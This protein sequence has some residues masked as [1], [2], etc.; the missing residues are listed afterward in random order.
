MPG[1][2]AHNGDE[3]NIVGESRDMQDDI[4]ENIGRTLDTLLRPRT[5]LP[6]SG[7]LRV[8][9]LGGMSDAA[10]DASLEVVYTNQG[11]EVGDISAYDQIPP[12]DILSVGLPSA[13]QDAAFAFALRFLR[14]RR[15]VAFLLSAAVQDSIRADFRRAVET[16][17]GRLG[18]RHSHTA[19]AF[20][21]GALWP[22][23]FTWPD[24]L[25]A[26][27]VLAQVAKDA[28]VYTAN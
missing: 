16:R 5:P 24:D 1:A 6:A 28:M 12:F 21:V 11:E 3:R 10:R 8:A 9:V 26:T 13:E 14:V 7:V 18:Y 25:T 4:G 20:I 2:D 17:A 27:A 22:E 19:D 23:P 15:P